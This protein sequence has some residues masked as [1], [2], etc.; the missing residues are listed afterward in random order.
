MLLVAIQM[1]DGFPRSRCHYL[2]NLRDV[3]APHPERLIR[4]GRSLN[5]DRSWVF[6]VKPVVSPRET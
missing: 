5:G 2:G 4:A 1:F 6:D 3:R